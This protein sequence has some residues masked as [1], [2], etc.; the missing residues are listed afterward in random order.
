M[1]T[2]LHVSDVLQTLKGE[3]LIAVEC[4]QRDGVGTLISASAVPHRV[5]RNEGEQ[6]A[7]TRK[8]QRCQ[9]RVRC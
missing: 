3:T 4:Q 5:N 6:K 2:A 1:D 9:W 8:L 7:I